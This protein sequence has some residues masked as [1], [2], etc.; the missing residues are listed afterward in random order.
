MAGNRTLKLSI[1]ADV[2][3]LRKSLNQADGDVSGF[4][5]K[6]S[7]YGKK[8]ALAFA[9]SAGAIAAASIEMVKNAAADEA[10]QRKLALTLENTSNATKEQIAAVEDYITKISLQKGITDDEL[11]P[12]IER[13]NRSTKNVTISQ[14]LLNVALDV[15]KGTGKPLETVV[16]AL[17]KAYDGNSASLGR[18]GLGIDSSILKSKDFDAIIIELKKNFQGFADQ[19]ANTFEGKLRRLQIGFDEAKE[20]VG[21]LILDAITPLVDKFSTA[22]VPAFQDTQAFVKDYLIPIFKEIYEFTK[23]LFTP[24]IDGLTEAFAK[25]TNAFKDNKSNL[26]PL[27]NLMR[28]LWNFTKDY[29]APFIGGALKIAFSTLGSVIAGVVNT[30]SRLV[31][32]VTTAFNALKKLID[33]VRNNPLTRGIGDLFGSS[34]PSAPNGFTGNPNI[35]NTGA[36]VNN[37]TVNGA[38]DPISTARQI[39]NILN[40]EATQSGSFKSLGGNLAY[41]A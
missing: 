9:A 24:I 3:N 35:R 36:P 34:A 20:S 17:S 18:L 30:V 1:L 23:N 8:A 4:G 11:R 39:A 10:A 12:A 31:D 21:S 2:D 19:E 29:L 28:N 14:E 26:E 40:I 13:L 27:I 7:E 37:I 5:N 25:V 41:Q 22:L 38:I 6:V 32:I 16:A 33:L 15:A